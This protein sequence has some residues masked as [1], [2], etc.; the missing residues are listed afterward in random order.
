[1]TLSEEANPNRK[2]LDA[3][4]THALP[5]LRSTLSYLSGTYNSH[6]VTT[7]PA[8][9]SIVFSIGNEAQGS[10]QCARKQRLVDTDAKQA[11]KFPFFRSTPLLWALL[12]RT[13]TFLARLFAQEARGSIKI[14]ESKC[15]LFERII[16]TVRR[17]SIG[18]CQREAGSGTTRGRQQQALLHSHG[19]DL[20]GWLGH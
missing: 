6:A 3:L 13:D 4:R 12:L 5:I 19:H 20:Y 2:V 15:S 9:I 16:R 11:N 1:M 8:S 14:T 7:A 18:R 10:Q 17:P